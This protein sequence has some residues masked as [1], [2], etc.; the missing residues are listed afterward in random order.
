MERSDSAALHLALAEH[1]RTAADLNLIV[2]NM[3]PGGSSARR[4]S[5]SRFE[6]TALDRPGLV[7][8]V[9]KFF[10]THGLEVLDM[11]CSQREAEVKGSRCDPPASAVPSV[12][13]H[14]LLNSGS[15]FFTW[16]AC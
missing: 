4:Q 13:H 10:A 11:T 16:R 2:R 12:S 1:Q 3:Q 7:H 6:L 15:A 8:I 14:C 5:L 9:T